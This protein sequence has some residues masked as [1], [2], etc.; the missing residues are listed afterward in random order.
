[1]QKTTIKDSIVIKETTPHDFQW[2]FKYLFGVILIPN[3]LLGFIQGT[4]NVL[5]PYFFKSNNSR[6]KS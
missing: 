6:R 2:T 4:G 5:F 3:F 1:M